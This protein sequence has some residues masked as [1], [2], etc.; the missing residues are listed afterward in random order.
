MTFQKNVV[1]SRLNKSR[2]VKSRHSCFVNI[3]CKYWIPNLREMVSSVTWRT[4]D[5]VLNKWRTSKK[6]LPFSLHLQ[7]HIIITL[8]C[9]LQNH[10][11]YTIILVS[12]KLMMQTHTHLLKKRINTNTNNNKIMIIYYHRR[13]FSRTSV[14]M[15]D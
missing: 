4:K 3:V 2:K 7:S 15:V 5:F 1:I 14:E 9:A 6:F 11:S 8:F 13:S 12:N 10:H